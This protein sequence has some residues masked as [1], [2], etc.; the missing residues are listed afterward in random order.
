MDSVEQRLNDQLNDNLMAIKRELAGARCEMFD[1]L[2]VRISAIKD[3]CD[4]DQ[5]K[6]L[7]YILDYLGVIASGS[8]ENGPGGPY[9]MD[10][11]RQNLWH[12]CAIDLMKVYRYYQYVD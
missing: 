2:K 11:L 9:D 1:L 7:A 10:N 5:M 3:E 6:E 8:K 4:G 12:D